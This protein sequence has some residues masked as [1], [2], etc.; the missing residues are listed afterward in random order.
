VLVVAVVVEPV[1]DHSVVRSKE[2]ALVGDCQMVEH[3]KDCQEEE[4]EAL[5]R[6]R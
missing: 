4:E 6:V 1:V 3:P 2:S 5:V